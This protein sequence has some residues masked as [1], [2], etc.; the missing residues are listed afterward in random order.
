LASLSDEFV[1]N[2]CRVR[3]LGPTIEVEVPEDCTEGE[4]RRLANRYADLLRG[5]GVHVQLLT[6]EEYSTLPPQ[7][8]YAGPDP[9]GSTLAVSA[10]RRAR[11]ALLA[12]SD[13]ILRRC[14]EYRDQMLDDEEHALFH[15][16]KLIETLEGEVG[17]EEGL[18]R[19]LGMRDKIKYVKRA[20]NDRQMDERHAPEGRNQ[21]STQP[22]CDRATAVGFTHEILRAFER[23]R[24][25]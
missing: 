7:P 1:V 13:E 2:D 14:Y 12:D 21:I 15:A 11:A 17:G 18:I 9:M 8:M 4:A 25:P 6:F 19:A 24:R 23:H 10:V 5:G 16:Y 20:A 22:P 3:L